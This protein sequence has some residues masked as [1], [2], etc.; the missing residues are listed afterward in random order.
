MESVSCLCIKDPMVWNIKCYGRKKFIRL[1]VTEKYCFISSGMLI[2]IWMEVLKSYHHSR[3]TCQ[4][5]NF[6]ARPKRL[7]RL[8]VVA[9]KNRPMKIFK[10]I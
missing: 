7:K 2:S 1:H 4:I 10:R 6:H 5:L 9:K 8:G 3:W